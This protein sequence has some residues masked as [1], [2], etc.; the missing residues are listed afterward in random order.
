[1][2]GVQVAIA[3]GWVVLQSIYIPAWSVALPIIFL[4][5]HCLL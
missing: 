4:H 5:M 3:H 1:M 2:Y